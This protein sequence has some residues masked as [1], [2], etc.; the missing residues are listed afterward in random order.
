MFNLVYR[1]GAPENT[2]HYE[3]FPSKESETGLKVGELVSISMGAAEKYSSGRPYGVV[4]IGTEDPATKN[5]VAHNEVAVLKIAPDMIFRAPMPK[6]TSL[7]IPQLPGSLQKFDSTNV[8]V[9]LDGVESGWAF[10]ITNV[11]S[12]KEE[13]D[14][15]TAAGSVVEGRFVNLG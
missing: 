2:G 7:T 9:E 3:I 11:V 8:V 5:Q 12:A 10:E 15:T 1:D 6:K 4:A 14:G 13:E